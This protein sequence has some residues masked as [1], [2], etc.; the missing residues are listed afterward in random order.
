MLIKFKV[1]RI[2]VFNL[3]SKIIRL[4]HRFETKIHYFIF[5]LYYTALILIKILSFFLLSN[6]Q[7]S[8]FLFWNRLRCTT[9]I[10]IAEKIIGELDANII[11]ILLFRIHINLVVY[12]IIKIL[13]LS[14]WV[15]IQIIIFISL[16]NHLWFF[17]RA[18]K[19]QFILFN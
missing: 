19:K 6:K 16:L 1:N 5:W 9:I 17:S 15:R 4:N 18:Y 3:L 2:K 11:F 10:T 8:L 12:V 7:L 14:T 13:N